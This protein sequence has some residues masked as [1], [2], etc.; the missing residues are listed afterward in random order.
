[1]AIRCIPSARSRARTTPCSSRRST[2]PAG[3]ASAASSRSAGAR[4]A[5]RAP[6]SRTGL[7]RPGRPSCADARLAVEGAREAVL[8]GNGALLPRRRRQG[9]D[10][11]APELRRLQPGDDAAASGHR[12]G[13]HRLQLRSEPHVLAGHRSRSRRSAPWATASFTSTRRTAR[14]TRRTRRSTACST[15]R[16]T[17]EELRTLVDLPHG[18]LRQPR[19]SSG[20]TSSAPCGWSATTT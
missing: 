6:R 4:P 12:A 2:W 10:R 18:R 8:E 1:M 17:R 9:G 16:T 13:R 3:S 11:D 7:W 14:S 5:I 20:R 15:P 19:S